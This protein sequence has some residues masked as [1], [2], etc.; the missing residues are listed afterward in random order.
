MIVPM[1]KVWVIVQGKDKVSAAET[2][3]E[4][5]TVHIENQVIPHIDQTKD[6]NEDIKLLTRAIDILSQVESE[7]NQEKCEDWKNKITGI[8]DKVNLI[9]TLNENIIKSVVIYSEH[10]AGAK[11][12]CNR[13]D[14]LLLSKEDFKYIE[15]FLNS[16]LN[17]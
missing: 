10:K 4:L 6:I 12:L 8:V 3:R 14:K 7:S 13:K 11:K 9:N 1:K 2:L 15:T 5:G 16:I 17:K